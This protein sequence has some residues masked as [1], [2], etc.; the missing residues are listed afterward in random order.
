MD[1]FYLISEDKAYLQE[2]LKRIEERLA[3]LRLTLN[4]KTEIVPLRTGLRF[5]GFHTYLTDDGNVIRKLTGENKRQIKKRLR[6]SAKLVLE[7]KMTRQKFDEK[8][9]S[10]KNHASHGNCHKLIKAMDS[11]VEEL[12]INGS[13]NQP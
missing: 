3:S 12:F 7:G 10:W 8:Y 6:K 9:E 11:F 4:S 1:D 2:C 5:R 13:K